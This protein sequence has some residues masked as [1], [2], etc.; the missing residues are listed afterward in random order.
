MLPPDGHVHTE[1]S[2]DTVAG[3]MVRSCERAQAL[4]L[5]SI[6]FTE[7]ADFTHWSV[8]PADVAA[9]PEHLRPRV[10]GGRLVPPALDLAGYLECVDRCRSRFPGLRV[11]SG[12]EVG[13]PHWHPG[14]VG[15]LLGSGGV[16]RVLGSLHTLRVRD[17]LRMVDDLYGERPPLEVVRDYLAELLRMVDSGGGFAVLAHIDYPVRSWPDP[18]GRYD[19][20]ELAD[21][22]RAVLRALAGTGRALEL[23]TTVPLPAPV[24]RWWYEEGG[25]AV[26][27][28]SDAHQPSDVAREF[29]AAA[30][31][32]S[33][34]GFRPGRHPD[35]FWRRT[36]RC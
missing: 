3:S 2:W 13:E 36:G 27:F 7:H 8:E 15:E 34:C 21:E 14:R 22:H 32:A 33:A 1:W 29:A 19:P 17:Q 35:D 25:G 26:C 31:L 18:A 5:P 6:A 9:L 10:A 20:R 11:R 24:L 4:G 28:G 30:A 12:V 23:N 16:D